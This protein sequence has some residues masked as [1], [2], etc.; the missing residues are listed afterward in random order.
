MKPVLLSAALLAAFATCS[1]A[2][3]KPSPPAEAKVTID[4]KSITIKYSA[5]SMRGRKIFGG[6]VPY[7]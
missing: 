6:L 7:G 1:L 3:D 4:V 5:P 2:Q